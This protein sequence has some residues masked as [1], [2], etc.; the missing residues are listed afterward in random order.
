[1]SRINYTAAQINNLLAKAETSLQDEDYTAL[2]GAIATAK[3]GAETTA[4]NYTDGKTGTLSNLA[5]TA[6]TN[7]VAAI[8]E[9][10][11]FASDGKSTIAA[12]ITG[13]GVSAAASNTWAQLATKI[14][15]IRNGWIQ[16]RITNGESVTPT[17]SYATST[18]YNTSFGVKVSYTA[19]GDVIITMKAGTTTNYEKLY[20]YAA[21]LPSGVTLTN[22]VPGSNVSMDAGAIYSC[23]LSGISRNY[24]LALA[25]STY[26]ST[27]DYTRVDITL[28][29]A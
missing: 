24:S 29:A 9:L 25:M 23:V 3:S 22:Y 13:M 26:N 28:T 20:F 16:P 11:Q 19:D 8:N 1:M 12:A 18:Y 10:F 2:E 21:S 14:G 4:K 5:T 27:N 6:K 15:Q 17:G 7:L